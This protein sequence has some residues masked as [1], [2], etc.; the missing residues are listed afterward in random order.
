MNY[1]PTNNMTKK[2]PYLELNE[3]WQKFVNELYYKLSGI[4]IPILDKLTVFLA[5]VDKKTIKKK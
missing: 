1:Q 2:D 5:W 4:M 3:A